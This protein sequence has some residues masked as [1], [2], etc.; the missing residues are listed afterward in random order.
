MP[1]RTQQ[2][3]RLVDYYVG[4]NATRLI[5][6]ATDTGLFATLDAAPEG[7]RAAAIA[8]RHGWQG[9][10]TEHLLRALYA[11]ELVE[12]ADGRWRL[13]EHMG[14]LLARPS[15]TSYLGSLAGFQHI[16][17]RDFARMP[18]L[19]A[20]GETYPYQAHEADFIA[21]VAE[22]TRGIAGFIAGSVVPKLPGLEGRADLR[23]LD[24]GCGSGGAMEALARALPGARI[25]GLDIEP[26][27]VDAANARLAA[28][29]VADRAQARLAGAE[30][31]DEAGAYDLVTLI[32][33]LHETRPAVRATIVRRA[34]EA[35]R[36]G[37][38]LLVVDEPYPDRLEGL[39]EA[40]N[41]AVTQAL[42]IFWGNPFVP[43]SEQ[44]ALLEEAG[45]A[46]HSQG[47]PPPGLI[48]VTVA[49]RTG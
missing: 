24:L 6:L 49:R 27:S 28:A 48:S 8:Q 29:G 43:L 5:A 34:F 20:S 47:V 46:I 13:A 30:S 36:P 9:E 15:S 35:L 22:V 23:I 37:G 1:D 38:V 41:T 19:L 10:Y 17:G 31:V 25:S 45:F 39:R 7:L 40:K 32:Q 33:V 14:T 18:A 11:L 12:H 2:M 44:R 16:C 42:E 3:Q 26:R 21:G 4:Y